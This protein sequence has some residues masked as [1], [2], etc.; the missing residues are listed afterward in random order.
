MAKLRL[1]VELN[2]GRT[3]VPLDKFA[4]VVAELK[5]FVEELATQVGIPLEKNVWFVHEFSNGSGYFTNE[6]AAVAEAEKRE[7]FNGF[8]RSLTAL[9]ESGDSLSLELPPSIIS[10]FAKVT[11]PLDYDE[12]IGF[13]IYDSDHQIEPTWLHANKLNVATVLGNIDFEARYYGSVLGTIHSLNKGSSPPFINV[14]DLINGELVK[15]VYVPKEH[16][17]KITKLLQ[18]ED[19]LVYVHG[20]VTVNLVS[21]SIDHIDSDRFEIA[22]EYREGDLEAFIGSAPRLTGNLTTRQY[23][24]KIRNDGGRN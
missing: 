9:P 21:K 5:K 13:G 15:C 23:I 7:R 19:A 3:G 14:R 4:H 24:T 2:K 20:L 10:Q 16:Y 18:K 22:P 12:P 6:L 1:R 8:M 11:D 17:S